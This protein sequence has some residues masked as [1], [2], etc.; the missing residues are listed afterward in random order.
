[1]V[2]AWYDRLSGWH[3]DIWYDRWVEE[4]DRVKGQAFPFFVD[5]SRV[6]G[7]TPGVGAPGWG[8]R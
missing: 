6:K 5:Q 3:G 2:T 7:L 4:P 1:M 8:G